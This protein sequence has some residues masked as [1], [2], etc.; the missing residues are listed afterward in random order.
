[1]IESETLAKE[2][3][4]IKVSPRTHQRL[5]LIGGMGDT[6]DDVI[7][8]LLDDFEKECQAVSDHVTEVMTR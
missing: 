7:S 8:K 5:M 4:L 2:Y 1:M 3:K 6:F